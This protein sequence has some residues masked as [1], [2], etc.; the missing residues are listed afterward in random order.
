M[1]YFLRIKA[2]RWRNP[3]PTILM[4]NPQVIFFNLLGTMFSSTD[5]DYLCMRLGIP[6]P[7]VF[8]CFFFVAAAAGIPGESLGR[9]WK[10]PGCSWG[11]AGVPGET[12]SP[13]GSHDVW[14]LSRFLASLTVAMSMRPAVTLLAR[15]S[16]HAEAEKSTLTLPMRC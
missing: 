9:N 8:S 7:L 3:L 12:G 4:A 5:H 15:G 2:S 14:T 10:M 13:R 6:A 1:F 16:C 11:P